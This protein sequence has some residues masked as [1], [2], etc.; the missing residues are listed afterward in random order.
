MPKT[1]QRS[2]GY[3]FSF[4]FSK[5]PLP[6]KITLSNGSESAY[7]KGIKEELAWGSGSPLWLSAQPPKLTELKLGFEPQLSSQHPFDHK[8]LQFGF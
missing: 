7:D 2:L 1:L 8:V 3:S 6:P 4:I 5:P